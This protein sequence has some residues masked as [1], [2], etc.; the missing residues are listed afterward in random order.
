[1]ESPP[2]PNRSTRLRF[3]LKR[4]GVRRIAYRLA[5]QLLNKFLLFRILRGMHL[6][7]VNPDYLDCPDG[8]TGGFLSEAQLRRYAR[9]ARNEL[10]SDFLDEALAKGDRCYGI[11]KDGQLASYSWYS[12]RPTRIHPPELLLEFAAP[13]IYMYK[14]LTNPE[15]RGQRLYAIGMNRALQCYQRL[16]GK[17]LLAYVESHNLDS[18]KACLRLGYRV[19]GSIH[20]LQVAGRYGLLA[21]RGCRRFGFQLRTVST[22]LEVL[23]STKA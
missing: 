1:M 13:H 9:D 18:L 11:L 6:P 17:G 3:D 10:D 5:I 4:H 8:F 20:V 14:G 22:G 23:G 19:F 15:F 12:L 21:T 7:E 16:G 2:K